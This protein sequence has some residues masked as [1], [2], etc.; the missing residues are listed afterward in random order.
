MW[1]NETMCLCNPT[2]Q[3]RFQK[4]QANSCF[5]PKSDLRSNPKIQAGEWFVTKPSTVFCDLLHILRRFS[6]KQ[7]FVRTGIFRGSCRVTLVV[8]VSHLSQHFGRWRRSMNGT[9]SCEC[10][11]TGRD[12]PILLAIIKFLLIN[13]LQSKVAG[14]QAS[15]FE[16]F[17]TWYCYLV[18]AFMVES[19]HY[20]IQKYIFAIID[21]LI[22]NLQIV[23]RC[24]SCR[25]WNWTVS[26]VMI[27]SQH[28]IVH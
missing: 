6:W 10:R 2:F 23:M 17:T 4:V 13:I 1:N 18:I 27:R 20:E 25:N 9:L 7:F 15:P 14:M 21:T 28:E 26:V 16:T 19:P 22:L 11:L 8:A 12:T 24:L 5:F 3:T